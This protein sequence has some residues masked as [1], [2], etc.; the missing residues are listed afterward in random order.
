MTC[1]LEYMEYILQRKVGEYI[2]QQ[3]SFISY[4]PCFVDSQNYRNVRKQFQNAYESCNAKEQ[5]DFYCNFV[6]S[7]TR[8]PVQ[9]LFLYSKLPNSSIINPGESKMNQ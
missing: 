1:M 4:F 8:D 2:N 9:P 6:N 7:M 3:K 5:L